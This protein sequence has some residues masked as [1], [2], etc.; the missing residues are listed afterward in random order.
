MTPKQLQDPGLMK[1]RAAA[2]KPSQ[3]D[4][5]RGDSSRSSGVSKK[6]SDAR[7]GSHL[8]DLNEILGQGAFGI[9]YAGRHATSG[10]PVAVKKLTILEEEAGTLALE[11]IKK[12]VRLPKHPNLV[13]LIDY[14]FKDNAFWLVLEFCTDGTLEEFVCR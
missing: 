12:Y 4:S 9:V 8:V 2:A 6:E 11:E 10:T 1:A 5:G 13:E 7:L 3:R 14:H